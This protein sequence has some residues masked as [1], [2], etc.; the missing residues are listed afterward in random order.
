M[1]FAYYLTK[2]NSESNYKSLIFSYRA[3]NVSPLIISYL[4]LSCSKRVFKDLLDK[5]GS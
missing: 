5:R 1:F 3:V 4:E 2:S